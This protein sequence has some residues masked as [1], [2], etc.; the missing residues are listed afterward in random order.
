M[1]DL[2]PSGALY[3]SLGHSEHTCSQGVRRTTG[4][5]EYGPHDGK[6]ISDSACA[7]WFIERGR[8][9]CQYVYA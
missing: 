8:A 1:L 4:T 9:G 6:A 3:C 5:A 7:Y 2:E